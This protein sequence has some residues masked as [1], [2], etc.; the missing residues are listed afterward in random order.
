MIFNIAYRAHDYLSTYNFLFISV[1]YIFI[2][3]VTT[4]YCKELICVI[5]IIVIENY[6]ISFFNFL[7]R[8]YTL[9]NA[10]VI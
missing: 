7:L 4:T 9:M 8:F 5:K 2:C 1:L 6:R 3:F 10:F